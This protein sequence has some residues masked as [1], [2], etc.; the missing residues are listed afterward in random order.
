MA[1]AAQ[2]AVGNTLTLNVVAHAGYSNGAQAEA[3]EAKGILPHVPANRAINNQGD[4]NLFDRTVFQYDPSSDTFRC[5]AGQTP[6]PQAVGLAETSGSL[7]RT[8]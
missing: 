4:R 7:C 5:P 3:C 2:K 1:E 8:S 6:Y